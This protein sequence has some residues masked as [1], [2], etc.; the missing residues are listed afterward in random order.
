MYLIL[1][2]NNQSDARLKKFTLKGDIKYQDTGIVV[3]SYVANDKIIT[4][5]TEIVDRRFLFSGKILE[6]TNATIRD[7][8][9]LELAIIYLEPN[10]MNISIIEGKPLASIMTGSKTQS[11]FELLNKME[12]PIYE[13]V[14]ELRSRR[15]AINDSIKN[16]EDLSLKLLLEKKGE[17]ISSQWSKTLDELDPIELRFVL[18]NPKSFIYI[19]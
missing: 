17:E 2:C 11:E 19:D 7:D 4:D 8:K 1:S 10:K 13:K 15:T 18:E 16:T 14:S 9:D 5:T 12:E 6:P 3:M